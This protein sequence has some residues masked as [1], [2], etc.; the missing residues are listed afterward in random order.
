M[1]HFRIMIAEPA[2]GAIWSRA[3]DALAPSHDEDDVRADVILQEIIQ[4]PGSSLFLQLFE[5]VKEEHHASL[6][7]YPVETTCAKGICYLVEFFDKI[8]S[9]V[10]FGIFEALSIF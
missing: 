5:G 1:N 7:S 4:Q 9:Q 10:P 8:P 6:A 3:I 2:F